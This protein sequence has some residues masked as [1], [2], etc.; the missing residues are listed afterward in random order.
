MHCLI[1]NDILN[2]PGTI[3]ETK[4]IDNC[5]NKIFNIFLMKQHNLEYWNS[6]INLILIPPTAPYTLIIL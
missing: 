3:S 4:K 2:S 6:K 1:S 5:R